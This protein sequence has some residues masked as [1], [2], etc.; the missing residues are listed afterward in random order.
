MPKKWPLVLCKNEVQRN[1]QNKG[2]F[3]GQLQRLVCAQHDNDWLK[4]QGL[5]SVKDQW[6]KFHYPNG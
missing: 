5:V 3:L 4:A 6:V 2:R 1:A